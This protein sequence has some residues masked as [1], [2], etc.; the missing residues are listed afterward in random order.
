M[1]RRRG[2]GGGED[3][4]GGVDE[5]A[6]WDPSE[7]HGP[8]AGRTSDAGRASDAGDRG[9]CGI[10]VTLHAGEDGAM[11]II[12]MTHGGAADL[13]GAVRVGDILLRI[14]D[15]SIAV[16]KKPQVSV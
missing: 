6:S 11:R 9:T 5:E 1:A 16:L 7:W 13:S 12:S 2:R 10:G 4:G 15:T 3:E 8:A 14:D